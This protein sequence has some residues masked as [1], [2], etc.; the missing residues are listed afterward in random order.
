MRRRRVFRRG[1]T[2][3]SAATATATTA[4]TTAA[5]ATATPAVVGYYSDRQF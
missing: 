3:A 2:A 5:P 4:A 1:G